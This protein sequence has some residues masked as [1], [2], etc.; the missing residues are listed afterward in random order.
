MKKSVFLIVLGLMIVSFG[1]S[2]IL[3]G[4]TYETEK[5]TADVDMGIEHIIDYIYLPKEDFKPS[6][7]IILSYTE[8]EDVMKPVLKPG[9]SILPYEKPV[10]KCSYITLKPNQIGTVS[11]LRHVKCVILN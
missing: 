10:Y 11:K 5:P 6:N 4:P 2:Q 9:W 3:G 1:Y 7:E 8:F